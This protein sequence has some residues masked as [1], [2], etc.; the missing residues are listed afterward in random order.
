[1]TKKCH[2]I[3]FNDVE[4]CNKTFYD[5][6]NACLSI[7]DNILTILIILNFYNEDKRIFLILSLIIL[8]FTSISQSLL[9]TV[10]LVGAADKHPYISLILFVISSPFGQFMPI[11]VYLNELIV[12]SIS[13]LSV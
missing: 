2:N 5:I 12:L 6:W 7:S 10:R 4:C 8:I 9:L 3:L 13:F 1:M 11:L